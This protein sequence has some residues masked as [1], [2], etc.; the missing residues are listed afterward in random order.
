MPC[1][2]YFGIVPIRTLG[3]DELGHIRRCQYRYDRAR[4]CTLSVQLIGDAL[5]LAPGLV[6]A[7]KFESYRPREA[8][9]S[10]PTRLR[11]LKRWVD[12]SKQLTPAI[13][14]CARFMGPILL[15]VPARPAT[16]RLPD[17][18]K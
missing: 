3:E 17:S 15:A 5:F 8:Y 9:F 14:L 18:D 2:K 4:E 7:L 11:F 1:Q 10:A 6:E 16:R 13:Q 12:A